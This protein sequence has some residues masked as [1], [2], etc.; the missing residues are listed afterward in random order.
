MPTLPPDYRSLRSLGSSS[1]LLPGNLAL[2]AWVRRGL[3]LGLSAVL[4]SLP[5]RAQLHTFTDAS[6]QTYSAQ[7]LS[8]KNGEVVLRRGDGKVYSVEISTLSDADR[9]FL[10]TWKPSPLDAQVAT[11]NTES[12]ISIKISVDAARPRDK[13]QLA[14]KISLHNEEESTDFKGLKGTLILIG[15]PVD[16]SGK[17]KVLAMEKFS[18]DVPANGKFDFS[19][20][21][22]DSTDAANDP[23]QPPYPYVG[24]LFVLQTNEGNIIQF[25]HS[26]PFVKDGLEALK[27]H[28]GTTFNGPSPRTTRP[29]RLINYPDARSAFLRKSSPATEA[30]P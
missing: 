9:Q 23:T 29:I 25:Q 7:V 16:G 13:T 10:T 27:L 30:Q 1:S 5:V 14:A 24:Y 11:A 18:G 4:T 26:A 22:F 17:F 12:A 19:G 8:A 21:S 15:Q 3:I 6:S 2:P 20:Q 28:I